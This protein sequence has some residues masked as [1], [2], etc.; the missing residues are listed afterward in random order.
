MGDA[1]ASIH[2]RGRIDLQRYAKCA[3]VRTVTRINVPISLCGLEYSIA[4]ERVLMRHCKIESVDY[5]DDYI[6][7]KKECLHITNLQ[8]PIQYEY[9]DENEPDSEIGEGKIE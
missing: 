5:I 2:H 8:D 9:C 7:D 6:D 4:E 1:H 3:I